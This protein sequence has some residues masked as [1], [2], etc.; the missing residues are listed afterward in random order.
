[1]CAVGAHSIAIDEQLNLQYVRS[2]AHKKGI[3]FGG[4]L[5]LT[6]ALSLGILSPRE[7]A[8]AC[9]AAG[10]NQGFVLSPGCDMPFN[11]PP[12]HIDAVLEAKEWY[13][14]YYPQEP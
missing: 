3:G 11:V 2:E 13:E 9:L 6:L 12:E 1:M 8:I 10:G 4:R 5:K 14:Q 7:D